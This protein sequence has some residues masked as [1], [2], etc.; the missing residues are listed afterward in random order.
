MRIGSE[1]TTG[2]DQERRR[3]TGQGALRTVLVGLLAMLTL[4]LGAT[5]A[6][7]VIVHLADGRTLSY[8][9]RAGAATVSPFDEFFT[10]LDYNGGPVMPSNTNYALYWVPPGAPAYPSDYRPGVNRY[11]DRPGSR[12]RR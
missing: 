2:A 3:A 8:Q 11:F 7:A 6:S 10:N 4:G 12:Q 9:P 5:S 1:G